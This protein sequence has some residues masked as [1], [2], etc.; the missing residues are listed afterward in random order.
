MLSDP[1]SR[2][3]QKCPNKAQNKM[4]DIS[5]EGDYSRNFNFL[6]ENHTLSYPICQ[7]IIHVLGTKLFYQLEKFLEILVG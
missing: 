3:W 4:A 5:C 6:K 2:K 7:K 1:Q